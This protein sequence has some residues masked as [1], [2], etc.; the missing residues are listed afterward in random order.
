MQASFY[1]FEEI[2]A[3]TKANFMK[4]TVKETKTDNVRL[5]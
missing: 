2:M 4:I 3:F 1:D 5:I